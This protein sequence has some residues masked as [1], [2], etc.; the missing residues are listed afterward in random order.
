MF[1][2]ILVTTYNTIE[3]HN[4]EDNNQHLVQLWLSGM[5]RVKFG[6]LTNVSANIRSWGSSVSIVTDYGL[7]DWCLIPDR[8]RGFFS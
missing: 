3:H 4:S 5:S 7:D 1:R 6:E 8:G 2:G